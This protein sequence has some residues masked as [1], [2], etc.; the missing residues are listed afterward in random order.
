MYC[1]L[2]HPL[3]R[4]HFVPQ[5]Q[6]KNAKQQICDNIE[7]QIVALRRCLTKHEQVVLPKPVEPVRHTVDSLSRVRAS[8]ELTH[9]LSSQALPSFESQL[10]KVSLQLKFTTSF[11]CVHMCQTDKSVASPIH[12]VILQCKAQLQKALDE[13]DVVA[14]REARHALSI[15]VCWQ[16]DYIRWSGS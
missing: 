5:L 7:G 12:S 6:S 15:K 3:T 10:Q 4:T 8:H 9:G 11:F 1:V 13:Q 14:L 16:T 2:T